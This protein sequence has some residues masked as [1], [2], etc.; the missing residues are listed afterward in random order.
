MAQL[1]LGMPIPI[2]Q[3]RWKA[4]LDPLLA[5]PLNSVGVLEG[6]KLASGPNVIN[7]LLGRTMQGWQILD[8]NA[9]VIP[10][11]SA[12]FNDLTLTLTCSAPCTVNIGVF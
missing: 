3:T 7:H 8:I 6:V 10:Y 4:L 11:R 1:P 9:A 2:L 12:P 5:N